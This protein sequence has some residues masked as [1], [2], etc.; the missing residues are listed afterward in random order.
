MAT[1]GKG[2]VHSA[3]IALGAALGTFAGKAGLDRPEKKPRRIKGK[4]VSQ[5]KHR[6]PRKEKKRLQLI[7]RAEEGAS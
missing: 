2:V 5:E 3:A 4:F 7:G 6:L 1:K